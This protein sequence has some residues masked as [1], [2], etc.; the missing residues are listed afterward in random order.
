MPG[1]DAGIAK[2]YVPHVFALVVL[3]SATSGGV[4]AVAYARFGVF[5]ANQTGNL[6]IVVLSLLEGQRDRA[7]LASLVSLVTFTIAVFASVYLRRFLARHMSG[8]HV[9]YALLGV[10]ALLIAVV[11]T[12]MVL[13]GASSVDLGSIALLAASQGLQAV[14]LTRIAGLLVS[15]VVINVALV[16]SARA[17]AAGMR[18]AAF[19]ALATPLGYLLGVSLALIPLNTLP[20]LALCGAVATAL[21][22]IVVVRLMRESAMEFD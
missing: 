15:T 6:V 12:G 2:G 14:L 7:M 8:L 1:T 10:E 9:R 4:D 5:V 16:Q 22:A 11:A 20:A 17:W 3:L 21:G 19:I 18:L 13:F